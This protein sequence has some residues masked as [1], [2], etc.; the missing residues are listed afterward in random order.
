MELVKDLAPDTPI[1]AVAEIASYRPGSRA[2]GAGIA[3]VGDGRP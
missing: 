1:A 2:S 3:T